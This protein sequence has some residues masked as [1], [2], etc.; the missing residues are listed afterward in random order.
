MIETIG[1]QLA[2]L[3][4][5]WRPIFDRIAVRDLATFDWI[6]RREHAAPIDRLLGFPVIVDP[7]VDPGVIEIRNGDDVVHRINVTLDIS[8]KGTSP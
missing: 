1:Q 4:T 5:A 2:R 3:R 7:D 6:P 8:S